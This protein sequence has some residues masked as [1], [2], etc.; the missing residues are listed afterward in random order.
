MKHLEAKS[1]IDNNCGN[2]RI[3]GDGD[4]AIPLMHNGNFAY[5]IFV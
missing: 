1:P 4:I 3:T 2:I 5:H